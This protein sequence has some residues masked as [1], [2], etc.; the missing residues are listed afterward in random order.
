[1]VRNET[2]GISDNLIGRDVIFFAAI[3]CL[4]SL[5]FFHTFNALL[6]TRALDQQQP[7]T[8]R[9]QQRQLIKCFVYL[10]QHKSVTL[11]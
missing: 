7:A 5:V 6:S 11:I 1:M 9:Q 4:F 2:G 10:D 8:A 3:I